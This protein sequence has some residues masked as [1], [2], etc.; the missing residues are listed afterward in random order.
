MLAALRERIVNPAATEFDNAGREQRKI[1]ALRLR[2]AL[3]S[4]GTPSGT[5]PI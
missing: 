3:S 2:S 1:T 5:I 4:W